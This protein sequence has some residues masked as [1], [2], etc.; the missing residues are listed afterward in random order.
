MAL[1]TYRNWVDALNAR[2]RGRLKR[3][4]APHATLHLPGRAEPPVV[5]GAQV[6]DALCAAYRAQ[7]ARHHTHRAAV[8]LAAPTASAEGAGHATWAVW[9]EAQRLCELTPVAVEVAILQ[10]ECDLDGAAS[11]AARSGG[12]K[13][14][15]TGTITSLI[16]H[17]HEPL[18]YDAPEPLPE[19]AWHEAGLRPPRGFP[20]D[21]EGIVGRSPATPRADSSDDGRS[22]RRPRPSS[23][24][25][26]RKKKGKPVAAGTERF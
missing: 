9:A 12:R 11:A 15:N 18:A 3:L 21:G 7:G 23:D 2:H 8:T 10:V 20:P 19:F 17:V 14:H 26:K 6:A 25:P 1:R 22:P 24:K 4:L 5:G 13:A 16:C